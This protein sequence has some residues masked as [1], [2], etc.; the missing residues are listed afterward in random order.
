[1]AGQKQRIKGQEVEILLISDGQIQDTITAVKNFELEFQ[2]EVLKEGY[3]GEAT[4]RRDDIFNGI[5]GKM[6]VDFETQDILKLM[7]KIVS[8]AQRREPGFKI[9][10]KATLNFPNGDRPRVSIPNLFFGP[11]PMNVGGREQYVK[12]TLTFE[13]ENGRV[14]TS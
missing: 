7:V 4:M 1:M 13:A 10:V 2:M 8:R 5:T 11:M 12:T 9:N 3:V 14:L 6:D